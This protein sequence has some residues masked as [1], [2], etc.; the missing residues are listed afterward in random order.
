MESACWVQIITSFKTTILV[1]IRLERLGLATTGQGRP[2]TTDIREVKK[3]D[4]PVTIFDT[5][6]LEIIKSHQTMEEVEAF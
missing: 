6:G 3:Q 5:V 2:V 1:Q 4:V